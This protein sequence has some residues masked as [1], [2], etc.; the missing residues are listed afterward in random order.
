MVYFAGILFWVF[1]GL[2]VIIIRYFK[3]TES[4][5]SVTNTLKRIEKNLLKAEEYALKLNCFLGGF[6]S[7]TPMI[8]SDLIEDL[9][10][11]KQVGNF[12]IEGT[13]RLM[14]G[15]YLIVTKYTDRG[16]NFQYEEINS[17][18]EIYHINYLALYKWSMKEFVIQSHQYT[19]REEERMLKEFPKIIFKA[20]E[21]VDA[22]D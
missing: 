22:Q 13:F 2:L 17:S 5:F 1:V 12:S 8:L 19:N 10:A 7:K 11:C 6:R 14:N 15:N 3:N 16:Y 9:E 4:K 20:L 21:D 18:T